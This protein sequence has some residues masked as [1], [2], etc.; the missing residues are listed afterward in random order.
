MKI[1]GEQIVDQKNELLIKKSLVAKDNLSVDSL[2]LISMWLGTYKKSTLLLKV[3]CQWTRDLMSKT[4][5]EI[6]NMN[7]LYI[8]IYIGY[9]KEIGLRV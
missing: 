1:Y 5:E 4:K 7:G 3:N 8:Y 6:E 2:P 9:C